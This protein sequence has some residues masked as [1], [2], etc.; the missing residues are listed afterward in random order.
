MK[1]TIRAMALSMGADVCGF[2]EIERFADA[3]QGFSPGGSVPGL[4][5]GDRLRDCAAQRADEGQIRGWCTIITT[6]R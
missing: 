6:R 4:P 2:A 5:N 3:P 1:E